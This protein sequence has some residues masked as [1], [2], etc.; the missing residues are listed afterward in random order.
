MKEKMLSI[1]EK[2]TG[3]SYFRSDLELQVDD[4]PS[5]RKAVVLCKSKGVQVIVAIQPT[6]SDG[7]LAPVLAQLWGKGLVFWASPE[8]QTGE[9]ISGNS[10]VGSHLMVATIRQ[11][12]MQCQF[13]YENLDWLRAEQRLRKAISL[14]FAGKQI[15]QTKL[16]LI[17]HQAPGFV[18]FHPNPFLMSR[19]F[20]TILQH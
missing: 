7:R 12:G 20:G 14:G 19:S 1:L 6:I 5:L 4:D 13:V 11:L 3:G 16:A 9:M 17:G 8:E 18:D 10:L 15:R 2:L